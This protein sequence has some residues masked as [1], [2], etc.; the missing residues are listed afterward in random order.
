ADARARP[1]GAGGARY[2][3]PAR[4]ST[5]WRPGRTPAADRLRLIEIAREQPGPPVARWW[6]WDA[7]ARRP[8]LLPSPSWTQ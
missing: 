2:G 6:R 7:D 8:A 5:G 3:T 4:G 1:S